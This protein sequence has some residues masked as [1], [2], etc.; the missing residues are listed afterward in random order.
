MRT[1]SLLNSMIPVSRFN[2]GEAGRIF[3]ELARDKTKIVIKNNVP[4]GVLL[5]PDEYANIIDEAADNL[6]LAEAAMRYANSAPDEFIS[7]R[8]FIQAIGLT[9]GDLAAADD[10]E[11][12]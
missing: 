6:L 11:I 1:V 4:V 12:E 7:E 2:K 3:D 10:V 5:S 8:A 9:D